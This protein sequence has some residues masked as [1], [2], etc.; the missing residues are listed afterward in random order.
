M[1][2]HLIVDYAWGQVCCTEQREREVEETESEK[3]GQIL[4]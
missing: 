4:K 3:K 2:D 1:Q